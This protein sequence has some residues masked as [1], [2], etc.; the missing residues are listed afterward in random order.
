M[1]E[2][3]KDSVCEGIFMFTFG[4]EAGAPAEVQTP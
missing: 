1:S 4:S 2:R 3:L